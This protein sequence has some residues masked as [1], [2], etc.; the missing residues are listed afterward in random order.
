MVAPASNRRWSSNG[1]EVACRDGEV[2]RVAFAIDTH[3]P[4]VVAWQAATTGIG[5]EMIRHLMLACDCP[6]HARL[7]HGAQPRGLLHPGAYPPQAFR[8]LRTRN[9]G[10]LR[11]ESNGVGEGVVKTLKRDHA[12]VR[13]RPDALTGLAQLAGWIED[14]N[15]NHPHSGLRMCSPREFIRSQ[16]QPAHCPV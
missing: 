12:R 1:L 13:P 3:D 7:R 8:V 15:E 10:L 6:R 4:E 14:T 11:P 2:V 5:G 16:S 9:L